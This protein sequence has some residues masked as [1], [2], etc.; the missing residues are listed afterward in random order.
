MK[1]KEEEEG[2]M[3]DRE[4]E[5]ALPHFTITGVISRNE[6]RERIRSILSAVLMLL[7]HDERERVS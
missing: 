3:S 7:H 5:R 6:K 4:R 1:K 2:I